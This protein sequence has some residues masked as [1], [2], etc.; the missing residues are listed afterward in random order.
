MCVAYYL[1]FYVSLLFTI[2]FDI[3][4]GILFD[5]LF[6]ILFSSHI[7]YSDI[8]FDIHFDILF[9]L[10]CYTH[11][12]RHYFAYSLACLR[13]VYLTLSDMLL[14]FKS[15]DL[16]INLA[17]VRLRVRYSVNYYAAHDISIDW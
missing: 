6:G 17:F 13:Y 4:S 16:A 8:L 11:R 3:L 15:C 10:L 1:A 12:H 14:V 5:M 9:D 2:Y 7:L